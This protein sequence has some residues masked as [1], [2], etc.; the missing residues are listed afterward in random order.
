MSYRHKLLLHI[1]AFCTTL[2][3]C[4]PCCVNAA[5]DQTFPSDY[6][7]NITFDENGTGTGSFEADKGGTITENGA[8]SYSSGINGNAL[9]ITEKSADNYLSLPEGI[10]EGCDAATYSFWLKPGSDEVP[11][12]P[13]MTTCDKEQTTNFEKYLGMLATTSY[14]T[15]E[16]YN[17][18][19]TRLSSV[20]TD[21]DYNQWKYVTVVFDH[22]STSIYVNGMLAA[23][24]NKE[25]DISSI[26][27]SDSETWIGHANWGSGEGF[28]GMIDD[29]KIYGRALTE[30]EIHTLAG[31]AYT[32]ELNKYLLEN[33][34]L[35]ISTNFFNNNEK[36]LQI[37]GGQTVTIKTT[38]KNL[39]TNDTSV[40]VTLTPYGDDGILDGT[41]TKSYDIPVTETIEFEAQSLITSQTRYLEVTVSD[42]INTYN[43]GK[44][45]KSDVEFPSSAPEDTYGT[46]MA[47][48]D[49]AI[50]KDPKTGL[51]Y[52][53][54]T[55]AYSG[56]YETKDGET[57]TDTYPMDTFVSEDLI[58]WERIDNNFRIPES[59]KT[60]FDE[61]FAPMGSAMNT[62]IW[63]PDMFYA[64]EDEEHPY[65]L[66]Y[67]LSTNGTNFDY[68]RSAIG[69]VKGE[70][71]TGPWTDCGIIIS[72]DE[73]DCNT[74]AIDSNI[75]EDENG[76]RFIIWG[77][78]Q[79]GIVQAKLASDGKAEGI[80]YTSAQTIHESSKNFGER[81][82]STPNG[83]QGP[84][85]PYM[86]NNTASG[87]R[88][89]FVS[90]GWLGTNYNVRVARNSLDNTWAAETAEDPHRKLTDQ[91]NRPVGT[92]FVDQVKEGGT[93]SELWGYKLIGSYQLGDGIT[94]YGNGH[95]SI[96]HD[97]DGNWYLVHHSRKV[98]DGYAALT[99]RKMLWTDEG[100]PVVSPLTYSG[101]TEQEIPVEMLYGTWDLSSVGQ[102]IFADGVTDVTNRNSVKNVD[103]PVLSSEIVILPDG[104]LDGGIGTWE[105]DGDHT[106]TLNFSSDGNPEDYEFYK[107]GDSMELYVLAGYD[108]D[109]RENALVMT[110]TDQNLITQ[111]AKKNNASESLAISD[112]PSITDIE[113]TENGINVTTTGFTNMS[114]SAAAFKDGVLIASSEP[115]VTADEGNPVSIDIN[116][117]DYDTVKVY[118]FSGT[119]LIDSEELVF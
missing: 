38:I 86:I 76:D 13:F 78:F 8:V 3:C 52:A 116:S 65:W 9:N 66:Y 26:F 80:D 19:G 35:V 50:F 37:E 112:A 97:D 109:Q 32:E 44:I 72:S 63:A 59:A 18:S 12:W 70:S 21:G 74:N 88:Y 53:Y 92:T 71:P 24:D 64:K 46:T 28:S 34:R 15:I 7:I 84:E 39:R 98:P 102:T 100:W 75:Y 107:N 27:T 73:N 20:T 48:H 95:N 40:S 79:K 77:S 113:K 82:F 90:Y 81:L 2:T 11:N 89:M 22:N 4:V 96:L 42:G 62:G 114:M 33:N 17:N 103:L 51:Y 36:I 85:G 105:F 41:V 110:G 57:L 104:T 5:D 119:T 25:V 45:Y 67:S 115:I 69:L 60:F 49:P 6:I 16:R 58:H 108:K 106:I 117:S 43:A 55:D 23:Q 47:A 29:F 14:Y 68:T 111:F 54:N 99:I 56:E 94:Y 31:D 91:L 118:I 10:L 83:H 93:T 1:T 87:Y 61:I 101:E 30:D